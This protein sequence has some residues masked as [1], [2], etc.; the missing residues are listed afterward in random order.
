[1]WSTE[2]LDDDAAMMADAIGTSIATRQQETGH[3]IETDGCPW[4]WVLSRFAQSA[5]PYV[6]HRGWTAPR[7]NSL[8]FERAMLRGE[9]DPGL[10]F[11]AVQLYQAHEDGA[12]AQGEAARGA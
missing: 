5:M 6:G 7:Q 2:P 1:M 10:L 8:L 4:S 11:E 3:D 12:Y 9:E